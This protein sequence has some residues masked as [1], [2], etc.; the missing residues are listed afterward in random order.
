[1]CM[2]S[3]DRGMGLSVLDP[4]EVQGLCNHIFKDGSLMAKP[5][6]ATSKPPAESEG[7]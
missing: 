1:M 3:Y 4:I 7:R 2:C 5:E 6:I